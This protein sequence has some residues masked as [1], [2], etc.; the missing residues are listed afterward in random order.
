M[1]NLE[2]YTPIVLPLIQI[3][4]Q[5]PMH[6]VLTKVLEMPAFLKW[7][8]GW[9]IGTMTYPHYLGKVN[10]W[11]LSPPPSPRPAYMHVVVDFTVI[12]PLM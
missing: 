4:S 2:S 10:D 9:Y 8:K 5:V 1:Y 6:L 3:L 7:K 11:I 12:S